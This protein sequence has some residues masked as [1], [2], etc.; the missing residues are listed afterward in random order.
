MFWLGSWRRRLSAAPSTQMGQDPLLT[1]CLGFQPWCT[2]RSVKPLLCAVDSVLFLSAVI[3]GHGAA[4]CHRPGERSG[5]VL[6]VCCSGAAQVVTGIRT[7]WIV[8]WLYVICDAVPSRSLDDTRGGRYARLVL[9]PWEWLMRLRSRGDDWDSQSAGCGG[10]AQ[11]LSFR[12]DQFWR[13]YRL[14]C[15]KP[16]LQTQAEPSAEGQ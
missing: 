5:Y 2:K 13:M 15:R 14:R 12:W 10:L 11:P 16:F 6:R 8:F 1:K 3:A 4:S 7:S 9:T